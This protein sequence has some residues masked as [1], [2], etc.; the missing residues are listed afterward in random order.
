MNDSWRLTHTKNSINK[1]KRWIAN[2][3]KH[4]K[5]LERQIESMM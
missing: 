2:E 1:R 5:E 3:N 4:K